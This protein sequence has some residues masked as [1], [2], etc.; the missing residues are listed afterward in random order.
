MRMISYHSSTITIKKFIFSGCFEVWISELKPANQAFT[1]LV[2]VVGVVI[3]VIISP[4]LWST[5]FTYYLL[6]RT[7]AITKVIDPGQILNR[8]KL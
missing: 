1:G 4:L 8:I 2:I 5:V 6:L 3:F 7:T